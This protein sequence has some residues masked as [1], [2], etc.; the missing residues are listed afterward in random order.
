[1]K[2]ILAVIIAAAIVLSCMTTAFAAET[3][4]IDTGV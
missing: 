3:N 4:K 2:K 1:M